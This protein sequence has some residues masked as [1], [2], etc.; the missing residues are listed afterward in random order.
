VLERSLIPVPIVANL[1]YIQQNMHK[2]EA[3]D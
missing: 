3:F 1:F 2:I